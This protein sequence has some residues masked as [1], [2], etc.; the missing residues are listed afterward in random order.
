MFGN[1]LLKDI[2]LIPLS[3]DTVGHR[4]NDMAGNVESQLIERVKKSPYYALQI[5]EATDVINDANLM[6][7]VRYVYD[8]NIHDDILF[9]RNLPT[10]TTGE[11]MF[12]TLDSYIRGKR[13]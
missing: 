7:Y 13:I 1:K 2:D 11:E 4:I 9:C 3:N 12:L 8:S 6:S 10:R 5:D